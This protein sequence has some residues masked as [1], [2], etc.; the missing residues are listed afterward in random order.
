MEPHEIEHE[1]G[2]DVDEEILAELFVLLDDGTP[3]GLIQACD[4]FLVGVP[5]ALADLRSALAE[6]RLDNARFDPVGK[7]AHTLRG[8]AG[9]FGAARLGRL[10][11]R[12]EDACGRADGA[13]AD[14]ERAGALVDQME[15]EFVAFRAVLTS[16][17]AS[18]TPA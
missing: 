6:A 4:M 3:D 14:A 18:P 17:L 8:T 5:T 7:I 13:T 1:E 15:G 16:R 9:A 11:T 2:N 10:A 12:L